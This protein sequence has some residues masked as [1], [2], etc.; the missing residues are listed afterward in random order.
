M[1][2]HERSFVVYVDDSGNQNVG[3]LWTALA[4]PLD[5]WS[6]YLG[7]WR[8]FR[9]NLMNQHSLPSDFELHGHAWL[10]QRPAKE[11]EGDQATLAL[12]P[13]G[14]VLPILERGKQSR[15]ARFEIFEKGIQTIGTFAEARILTTFKSGRKG[16]VGLYADLLCFLEDFLERE[17]AFAVV[18]V[19]GGHDSGGN[20]H[21]CHRALEIR[22]RRIVEDA[23]LRRSHESHLLQMVDWCAYSA[24]QAIQDRAN[25]SPK[26]K[27]VYERRLDRLIVRPFEMEEGRCIR[28]FD[29]DPAAIL[30]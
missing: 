16:K 8:G 1:A 14:E 2:R 23:G 26:F 29:Y 11:L 27:S 15:K 10:S 3:V 9:A 17:K 30:F 21:R 25:L 7:R 18:M 24:F 13:D 19:D 28:G 4:I 12:G 20:L 22:T 6:E 5:L